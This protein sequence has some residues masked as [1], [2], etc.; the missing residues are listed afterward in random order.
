MNYRDEIR[1]WA[2]FQCF[3]NAQ[4]TCVA[5]LRTRTDADAYASLLRQG[6][7]K[8]EVMFDRQSQQ[9]QG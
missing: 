1:P 6:G 3:P 2:I 8:F 5:R 4:N 9:I 7:G